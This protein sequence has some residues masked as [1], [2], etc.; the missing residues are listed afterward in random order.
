MFKQSKHYIKMVALMVPLP[1]EATYNRGGNEHLYQTMS[2]HIPL[3]ATNYSRKKRQ[4]NLEWEGF[5]GSLISNENLK[6]EGVMSLT[7]ATIAV[8]FD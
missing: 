2:S 3:K 4:E 5:I 6:W 8:T 1:I 7:S